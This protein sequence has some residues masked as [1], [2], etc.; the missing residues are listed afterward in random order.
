MHT[1]NVSLTPSSWDKDKKKCL[2]HPLD[3]MCVSSS[4]HAN[5][6]GIAKGLEMYDAECKGNPL[7]YLIQNNST[8]SPAKEVKVTQPLYQR[9][10]HFS[11]QK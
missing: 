4:I 3:S 9:L 2:H 10:E 1:K 5:I 6:K 11:L 8:P 7:Q